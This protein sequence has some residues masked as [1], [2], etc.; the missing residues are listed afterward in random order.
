M[1]SNRAN[2]VSKF[3]GLAGRRCRH[4]RKLSCRYLFARAHNPRAAARGCLAGFAIGLPQVT[5]PK[6]LGVAKIPQMAEFWR[7]LD[8]PSLTPF[9]QLRETC[10]NL[11]KGLILRPFDVGRVAAWRG[12]G[13]ISN[14]FPGSCSLRS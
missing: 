9:I 7:H 8:A 14:A 12:F 10:G 6:W 13:R 2:R 3:V 11:D 4:S 1:R 5:P